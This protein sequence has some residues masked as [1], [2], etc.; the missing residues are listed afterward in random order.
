MRKILVP[1]DFSPSSISAWKTAIFLA[2]VQQAELRVLHVCA[3]SF[4]EPYMPL[5][6]ETAL[7]EKRME[8]ADFAFSAWLKKW[9]PSEEVSWTRSL[10]H[11]DVDEHIL[12]EAKSW[13]ADLIIMGSG[14]ELDVKSKL[15]GTTVSTVLKKT[16]QE[17]ELLVIPEGKELRAIR[18]IVFAMTMEQ[19]RIEAIESVLIFAKTHGA[20]L[21]C[22]HF[23]EEHE[24]KKNSRVGL[25]KRAYRQELSE[26]LIN[27]EVIHNRDFE[28]G[29]MEYLLNHKI[30]LLVLFAEEKNPFPDL[31]S[32]ISHA[33]EVLN[34]IKIPIWILPNRKAD[35]V[36]VGGIDDREEKN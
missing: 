21:E 13:G 36:G 17:R 29:L 22:V 24:A 27:F 31:F 12:S 14:K 8:K 32:P 1:V 20:F 26:G 9:I 19:E 11:G 35:L 15:L 28:K 4:W 34:H 7:K 16:Q 6:L 10:L 30:N 5:L 25:L 2:K 33:E 18:Q 23:N 3:P